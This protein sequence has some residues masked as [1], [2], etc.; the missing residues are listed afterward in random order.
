MGLS[1]QMIEWDD[2]LCALIAGR[3]FRV[4][5]FDNRDVGLSAKLEALGTPDLMAMLAGNAG[6]PYSLDDMAEDSVGVLDAVGVGAAHIVGA[7]MGGMIAQLIAINHPERDLS[8]TSMMSTVGGP[9][10]VPAEPVVGAALLT[11]PGWTRE[12]QVEHS[13]A[14]RR[15]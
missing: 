4:T 7:S 10:V 9:N 3:G 1:Y 15:L 11:P 8:V 6:P 13:L 2:D 14:N 12:E 5:R